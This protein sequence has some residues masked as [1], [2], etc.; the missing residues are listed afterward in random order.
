MQ[1]MTWV[2]DQEVVSL[3]TSLIGPHHDSETIEVRFIIIRSSQERHGGIQG[4][5][6]I[7]RTCA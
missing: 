3:D 1:S 4:R 6:L 7:G 5:Y 2:N